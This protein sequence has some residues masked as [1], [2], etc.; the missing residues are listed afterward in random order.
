MEQS[1]A[2]R[3]SI[4]NQISHCL[5]IKM[6]KFHKKII[7]K[8]MFELENI[9]LGAWSNIDMYKQWEVFKSLNALSFW[10][11]ISVK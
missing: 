3:H 2:M 6:Q 4:F 9:L 5:I 7:P 1:R 8:W 11:A 10:L